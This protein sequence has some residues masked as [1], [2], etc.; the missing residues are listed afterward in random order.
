MAV[1]G[2][3][4]TMIDRMRA[5]SVVLL[6]AAWAAAA[7]AA[8]GGG[9]DDDKGKEPPSVSGPI[10][11]GGIEDPGPAPIRRLTRFEYDATIRDLLGDDSK[12]AANFPPEEEAYGF[13]NNAH[14]MGVTPVLVEQ[15]LTTAERLAVRA[16]ERADVVPV[17]NRTVSSELACARAFITKFGARAFRRPVT[18]EELDDLLVTYGDGKSQTGEYKGGIRLVVTSMLQSPAFLYRVEVAEQPASPDA[19]V[20]P[21]GQYELAS[22][23]SY[24]FWGSMPDPQLF[25]AAAAGELSTREQIEAQA[26]RMLKDPRAEAMVTHFHKEWLGLSSLHNMVKDTTVYPEFTPEL[27]D[28]LTKETEAFLKEVFWRDGT[29]D[30]FFSANYTFVN[31]RLAK[32]YGLPPP[33]GSGLIKVDTT[34][35][36]RF[37]FL[38]QGSFLARAANANQPSPIHRGKFVRERLLCDLLPPPPNNIVIKPPDIKPGST[39]RE[40]FAQ[41]TK[42]ATCRQCH[43]LM[44]PIGFGFEHYDGLGKYRTEEAG[45]PIDASGEFVLAD[46]LDGTFVGVPELAK[47]LGTSKQVANCVVTQWFRYGYGRTEMGEDACTLDRLR[48]TFDASGHDV[49]ELLVQLALTDAFRYRRPIVAAG[50][51]P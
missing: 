20:Q 2:L 6:A 8:C 38:T 44:D 40:R 5:R 4:S 7:L 35:A 42:D 3:Q 16:V 13:T 30:A 29:L 33:S 37:G 26:R 10:C 36:N 43:Q 1:F 15:Y 51:T 49:R 14:V 50:G 11:T 46:D 27:R 25:A 47:K 9:G 45:K 41:H 32:L 39:S 34:G 22:R 17:C 31:E 19:K 28:D 23:I 48:K 24:L 12:P 18:A 21:L